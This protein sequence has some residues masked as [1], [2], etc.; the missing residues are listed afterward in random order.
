[1]QKST[2]DKLNKIN[3]I[4]YKS[5]AESFNS[6]RKYSWEGWEVFCPELKKCNVSAILD[7]GCGNGRFLSFMEEKGWKGKYV[8]IDS[9]KELL[10]SAPMSEFKSDFELINMDIFAHISSLNMRH[11]YDLIVSFGVMHHIAGYDNRVLLMKFIKSSLSPGG[12]AIIALWKFM[13]DEK[14]K[15]RVIDWTTVDID[16][17]ELEPNDYLLDWRR[18]GEALR[19]CH[20]IDD[21]ERD[22]LILDSG[23]RLEKKY[24]ADG[25]SGILNEY[26]IIS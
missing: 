7:I 2:I 12:K 16:P 24:R 9:S 22:S 8:G 13:E 26:I 5:I 6:S 11:K 10:N 21:K 23:F 4:F 18:G 25:K 1:M 17:G 19:Y 14:Y 20:Y 3:L 15:G